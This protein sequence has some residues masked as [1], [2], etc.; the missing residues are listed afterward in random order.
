MWNSTDNTPSDGDGG[1]LSISSARSHSLNTVMY[2]PVEVVA[3]HTYSADVAVR[4]SEGNGDFWIQA[5]MVTDKPKDY[6]DVD[7]AEENTIGQLNSWKDATLAN[8]DGLMSAKAKAGSNHKTDVMKWKAS[9]TGTAYFALKVGTNKTSFSYSF[10][11][12]IL[13]DL[14]D[15]ETPVRQVR[16]DDNTHSNEA[17]TYNMSGQAVMDG[18]KQPGIY[19]V[20][21]GKR[22]KKVLTNR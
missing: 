1:A 5:F 8:Y 2:Q 20:N 15:I 4:G 10:D 7:L 19:I 14:T 9:A 21:D 22:S 6:A 17:H 13:K 3:G 12:F 16:S 11:N 18:Q